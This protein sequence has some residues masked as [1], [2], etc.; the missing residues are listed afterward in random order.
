MALTQVQGQMLTGS[1]NTTTTIQSNGTTAITIDSSQNVG[2][3]T[4]SPSNYTN[5]KTLGLSG[6]TGG[7]YELLAGSTLTGQFYNDATGVRLRTVTA[8]PLLF[9]TNTIERMR[10]N[11][12]GNVAIGATSLGNASARAA[13]VNAGGGSIVMQIQR[14]GE[15]A[16]Y[17]G[18]DNADIFSVW[19]STPTKRFAVTSAG[20]CQN[21]T[22]SYGTISDAKLKENIVD[23]TPKLEKLMQLQVK[24][25]AF[26]TSPEFKQIGFIAQELKQV[27]PSL[28]EETPDQDE[29]GEKTGEVTLGVKTTV[30]IPILVKAIQE[31]QAII[32]DLKNRI[33]T[34]EAK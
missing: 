11:S 10:I 17:I 29:N 25:Y 33:E 3:G 31:Q 22:G 23:A 16:S 21:T 18:S 13:I 5:Y 9:D 14:S 34:L 7:A 8:T 1:S 24:N 30:L 26:K 27:F 12:S 20:S 28:I 2:I 15:N 6:T 4:T 32:T 19:D